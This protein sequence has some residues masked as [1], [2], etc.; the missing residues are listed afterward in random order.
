[1]H[2]VLTAVVAAHTSFA[3]HSP[4]RE[5]DIILA[6]NMALHPQSIARSMDATIFITSSLF[7]VVEGSDVTAVCPIRL[8]GTYFDSRSCNPLTIPKLGRGGSHIIKFDPP[9]TVNAKRHTIIITSRWHINVME[10]EPN[11]F[12]ISNVYGEVRRVHRVGLTF[13]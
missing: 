4:R 13:Y 8:S 3:N 6:G 7:L 2:H 9:G 11:N 12:S 5:K 1:M 10:G